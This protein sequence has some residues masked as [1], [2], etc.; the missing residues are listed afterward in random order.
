MPVDIKYT[1]DQNVLE[2]NM[3]C[4]TGDMAYIVNSKVGNNGKI[5][6]CLRF[7]GQDLLSEMVLNIPGTDLWE[8]EPPIAYTL[9]DT[10]TGCV[11]G[12]PGL[13]NTIPDSMLRPLRGDLLD[14]EM[15]FAE[16]YY[17]KV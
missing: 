3:N 7:I 6:K 2:Q 11:I 15:I 5:V 13:I 8:V 9:I 17:E 1:S 4:K 14:D 10:D 12:L 16:E